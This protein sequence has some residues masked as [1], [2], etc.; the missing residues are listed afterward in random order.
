MKSFF[1]IF[2]ILTACFFAASFYTKTKPPFGIKTICIDAGHGGK[3]PGCHGTQYK[4]KDVALAIA[5]K[6]GEYIKKNMP[7]V[8]VVFTRT[9]D[10][11]PSLDERA[12]IANKAKADL[13]ICIHCNSACVLDKKTKKEKCNE[14]AIGAETYVMGLHKTDAN[15]NV[16]KRENSAI[17][18]EDDYKKKYNGFDPESDEG[19]I[20]M[21][22]QQNSF[23]EKS[24][25]FASKVQQNLKQT[26][27]R[28]DRG[29]KQA[30]FL[31]LWRTAMPSVLIETG[32]LTNPDDHDF[33]GSKE[34]Q[35]YMAICMFKSLRQYKD[36]VEG[37]IVKYDDEIEKT[38]PYV[39]TVK[40]KGETKKDSITTI[41]P[42]K[43]D[44]NL[45]VI[46]DNKKDT[47]YVKTVKPEEKGIIFRVQV[48][49]SE[50]K[51]ALDDEKFKNLYD[52]YE[53]WITGQYRYTSGSFKEPEQATQLQNQLRKK[54]FPD[55]FVVA[56]K[57]GKRISYNDA[58][59]MMKEN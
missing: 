11:F 52:M 57:N 50:K 49:S 47:F 28:I 31:V 2:W 37:R 27:G 4:E 40:P 44:S 46:K 3:D 18:M 54:G 13:F 26:A 41:K 30:G 56:F 36:D 22:I 6:L 24:L 58:I 43:K 45:I 20:L 42:E 55:A 23:L 14:D 34:G 21:S 15:L 1:N 5:L 29:V 38:K 32:F 12:Q 53:Y 59:K 7:D 51:L 35:D 33:L 17:L 9:T 10:I 16:A 19:Y 8:K 48:A 25:L 39:P